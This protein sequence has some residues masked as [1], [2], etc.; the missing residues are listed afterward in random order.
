LLAGK[1][2]MDLVLQGAARENKGEVFIDGPLIHNPEALKLLRNKGV[3]PLIEPK[4]SIKRTIVIRS[5]GISPQ[6]L[7]ELKKTGA[8]ILDATCPKV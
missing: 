6:Q 8:K 5:H 1:K 2:A 4:E 7:Q 3:V